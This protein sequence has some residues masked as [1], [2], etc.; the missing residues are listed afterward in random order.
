MYIQTKGRSKLSLSEY[1]MII[2]VE[3]PVDST[4]QRINGIGDIPGYNIY[5]QKSVVFPYT[6]KG[7][8]EI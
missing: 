2:Y 5:M 8:L 6:S 4:K 1:N 3:S 7:K